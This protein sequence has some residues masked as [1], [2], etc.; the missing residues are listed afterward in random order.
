MKNLYS[1]SWDNVFTIDPSY[2]EIKNRDYYYKDNNWIDFINLVTPNGNM[3]CAVITHWLDMI[4]IH[5][6]VV[7]FSQVP[8]FIKFTT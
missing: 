5:P 4:D 3:Q 1:N 2:N 6:T 8:T 7:I